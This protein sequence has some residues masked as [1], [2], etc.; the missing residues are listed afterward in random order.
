LREVFA[1]SDHDFGFSEPARRK[2]RHPKGV[3]GAFLRFLRFVHHAA[4]YPNRIAGTLLVGLVIAICVNALVLQHSRH[5]APLFRKSIALPVLPSQPPEN[6]QAATAAAPAQPVRDPISQ[7]LQSS[8]AQSVS[9]P[10]KAALSRRTG[11]KDGAAA[12]PGDPISQFLKSHAAQSPPEQ[13]RTVLAAQRA[14]VKLGFVL[15]PDGIV[16]GATRQAIEQFERDRG[17]PVHGGLT[18]KIS[19]ELS[20]QSGVAI[21]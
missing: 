9:A 8:A 18:S 2:P 10:E 4:D 17:L 21:E 13:S 1:R 6:R 20:A 11:V 7:L 16:G 15:Q 12:K 19:H 3:S 5:P 14:L